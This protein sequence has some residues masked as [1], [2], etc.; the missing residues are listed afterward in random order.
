LT[1]KYQVRYYKTFLNFFCTISQVK[2]KNLLFKLLSNLSPDF[3]KE[4]TNLLYENSDIVI[5]DV[6]FYKGS[7]SK[8][9]V[10]RLISRKIIK[11]IEVISFEPNTSVNQNEFKKFVKK[12]NIIWNHYTNALGN[13]D[14]LEKFTVLENFPPSGSSLNNIL[15]DS[16]WLKTRRFL[17]SPFTSKKI[18]LKT[19]E[20]EVKKIDTMFPNQSKMDILKIDVEGF[21]FEVLE[22]SISLIKKLKPIIQ[23]EI[24]SKKKNFGIYET[25]LKNLMNDLGYSEYAKKKHYTTHW[26]SDIICTDYLF[27][28]II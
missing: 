14:G 26:L 9:L 12:N 20:V 23:V 19:F 3:N 27:V 16:L 5:F 25:K 13:I 4:L 24:L 2:Y 15:V 6:G 18:N 17:F 22:G 1:L 21:S 28:P 10:T 11:K 7:F 8:Q